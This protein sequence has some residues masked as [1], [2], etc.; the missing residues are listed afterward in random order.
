MSPDRLAALTPDVIE[1]SREA[2]AFIRTQIGKVQ[3]SDIEEKE[4]NS[5]VSFVDKQ[6]EELLVGRLGALFPEAGFV[7]EEDTVQNLRGEYT[8]VIDPLDGTTNFLQ[9]IPVFSVSV[10]LAHH[11][12]PVLGCIIDI[13]QDQAFYA[14]RNGGAWLEG[15]P[16]RVSKKHRFA[17]AIVATG[18]PYY[19]PENMA[20]LTEIFFQVV[21]NARGVRRLGSAALDLAYT[22]CGRFDVFYETTLK[23]WDIAAGVVLVREAGGMVTDFDGGAEFIS[24]GQVAASNGLLHH[25]ILNILQSPSPSGVSLH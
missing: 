10:A 23:S 18:F 1:I 16:V 9:Q 12:E 11:T 6:A 7:T 22:A 5:L 17:E 21:C 15:N 25:Q 13:M 20:R 19:S 3:H 2:G 24:T 4:R 14:W 8:W